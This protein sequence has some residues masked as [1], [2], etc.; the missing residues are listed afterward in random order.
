MANKI[1]HIVVLLME[2]RSFDHMF[3][4]L[5]SANYQ[6]DGLTG[7]ETNLRPGGIE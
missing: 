1:D 4:F 3:G 7:T 2:N 5:K 6:I